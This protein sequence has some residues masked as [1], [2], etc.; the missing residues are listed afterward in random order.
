MADEAEKDGSS[1]RNIQGSWKI[2]RRIITGTLLFCAAT[3]SYIVFKGTDSHIN[4]TIVTSAFA[5]AGM[6]IGSYVFGAVYEDTKK[7]S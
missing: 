4:E 6:V 5:L 7:N 2:R 3:V 1:R